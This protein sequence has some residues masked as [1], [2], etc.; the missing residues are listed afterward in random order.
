MYALSGLLLKIFEV[1]KVPLDI[2]S[3]EPNSDQL[4]KKSSLESED[5]IDAWAITRL[6]ILA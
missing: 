4:A 5:L 1:Q 2:Y 6:Q 3:R